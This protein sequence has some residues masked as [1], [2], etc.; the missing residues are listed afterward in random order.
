MAD[1]HAAVRGL[2]GSLGALW[3]TYGNLL[4]L[5]AGAAVG[6]ALKGIVAVGADIEHTLEKIRVLGQATSSEIDEMRKV[7]F[8][9]G[10]GVQGPRDVA[11]ALS[12]L[13]LAGLNA[14]EAMQGVGATLNLAVAG[15]VSIEKASTTLVQIS[16][17]LGYGHKTSGTLQTWLLKPPP[18]RCRVST[19]FLVH[20]SLLLLCVS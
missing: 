7:V 9:L 16:T 13:T 20:S 15:D 17:S 5:I 12:V 4:P 3:M 14:K 18:C 1:T 2:S 11:Q 19:V 8:D 6:M 10:K